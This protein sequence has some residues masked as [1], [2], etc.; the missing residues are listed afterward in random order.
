[1][2]E[3]PTTIPP[4]ARVTG[5][6]QVRER[7]GSRQWQA[8]VTDRD[9]RERTAC[10]GAPMCRLPPSIGHACLDPSGALVRERDKLSES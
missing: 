3:P 8:R 9:G 5:H 7:G 1:M 4:E 6:L 2:L 10:S